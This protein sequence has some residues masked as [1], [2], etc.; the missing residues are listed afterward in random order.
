MTEIVITQKVNSSPGYI[1]GQLSGYY[2]NLGIPR[3]SS[4]YDSALSL[5]HGVAESNK[6]LS[7][8]LYTKSCHLTTYRNRAL[9]HEALEQSIPI[10]LT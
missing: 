2:K 1:F 8:L 6:N 10:A 3:Q 9:E 7:N 4:G 5:R